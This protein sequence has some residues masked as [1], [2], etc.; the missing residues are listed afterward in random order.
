MAIQIFSTDEKPL[1]L[2]GTEIN[3]ESL[4]CRLEFVY[5]QDGITIEA[6]LIPYASIDSFYQGKPVFTTLPTPIIPIKL[7]RGEEFSIELIQNA[8]VQI[9][10]NDGYPAQIV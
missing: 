2:I 4:Y 5:R 1:T 3:L 9:Y 7:Q 8:L 6:T 10:Q